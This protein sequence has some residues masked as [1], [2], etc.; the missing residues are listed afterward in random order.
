LLSNEERKRWWKRW[1]KKKK[2]KKRKR[3]KR[4]LN[5]FILLLDHSFFFLPF[6]KPSFPALCTPFARRVS[7]AWGLSR[8]FPCAL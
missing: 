4:N 2:K 7:P 8:G 5:A 1:K 3:K 6:L